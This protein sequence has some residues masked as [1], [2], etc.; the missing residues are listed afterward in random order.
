MENSIERGKQ[1]TKAKTDLELADFLE[2]NPSSVAGYRRRNT[3]PLEQGIK[4]AE[5]TGVSLDWL[6]LGKGDMHP[7]AAD[8]DETGTKKMLLQAWEQL[9]PEQ[10]DGIMIQMFKAIRTN[11]K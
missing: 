5:R 11:S 8:A 2:V 6:F 3:L 10:Q 1:A 7:Q 9:T 4:I